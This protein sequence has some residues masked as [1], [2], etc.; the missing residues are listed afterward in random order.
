MDAFKEIH[1]LIKTTLGE[2]FPFNRGLCWPS[3][4]DMKPATTGPIL[5]SPPNSSLD[6]SR[7]QCQPFRQTAQLRTRAT[8]KQ[9]VSRGTCRSAQRGWPA[10]CYC[11][12]SSSG[13][14]T[15]KEWITEP[16]IQLTDLTSPPTQ[17]RN[18]VF[19]NWATVVWGVHEEH[20]WQKGW[21]QPQ[22]GSKQ[23]LVNIL[24]VLLSTRSLSTKDLGDP[25]PLTL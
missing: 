17:Q 8:P 13:H 24:W 15:R 21:A 22:Q 1:E 4:T 19:P 14:L 6:H 7:F 9:C 18:P 12:L 16:Q 3:G 25:G 11:W 23:D 2:P 5:H 10:T 20:S